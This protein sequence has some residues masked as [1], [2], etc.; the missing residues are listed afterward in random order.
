MLVDKPDGPSSFAVVRKVRS[1]TGARAGHAGTLDPF[2]TGL[3]LVLLGGATRLAQYL[4][5]L[6]KRYETAIDLRSTTASG[7]RQ[8]EPLEEHAPLSADELAE[9]LVELRGEVLLRVPAVSAIK[10]DGERAYKLARRGVEVEMPMRESTVHELELEDYREGIAR[11]ALRVSS[12]TYVRAIA[13]ALGGH[14]VELRRTAVGPFRVEDADE[15]RVLPPL[16]ALPFLP[17]RELSDDEAAVLRN[18]R[19]LVAT[20]EGVMR[21]VHGDTLVAIG[22]GDGERI[23]PETVLP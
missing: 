13:D 3:L 19:S 15:E 2:A 14:C 5:G 7:D 10:I 21:L 12:G 6:E 4:V 22:R 20:D 1:R 18:G 9:R 17:R 11:I 23:R 8:G 16:E